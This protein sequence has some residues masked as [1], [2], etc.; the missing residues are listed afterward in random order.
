[1]FNQL[2]LLAWIPIEHNRLCF[3]YVARCNLPISFLV[4]FNTVSHRGCSVAFFPCNTIVYFCGL[5]RPGPVLI[6]PFHTAGNPSPM[7]FSEFLYLFHLTRH[8][9]VILDPFYYCQYPIHLQELTIVG[10]NCKFI[11]F[12]LSLLPSHEPSAYSLSM[13][14]LCSQTIIQSPQY[15]PHVIQTLPA[16]R[17]HVSPP[18]SSLITPQPLRC[19]HLVYVLLKRAQIHSPGIS[20][21]LS[22]LLCPLYSPN[23]I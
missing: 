1:M 18:S 6:F 2:V 9:L 10:S 5:G 19:T 23:T 20:K 21:T 8:L 13:A 7:C 12:C 11:H 14:S 22:C 16:L 4:V 15:R 3:L 17:A